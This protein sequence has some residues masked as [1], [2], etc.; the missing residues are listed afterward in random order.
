MRALRGLAD[1]SHA[2]FHGAEDFAAAFFDREPRFSRTTSKGT[3]PQR[4][5][6]Q[7]PRVLYGAAAVLM[8]LTLLLLW[9]GRRG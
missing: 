2:E 7:D 5:R 8:A 4:S 6:G 9:T 3:P 1:F